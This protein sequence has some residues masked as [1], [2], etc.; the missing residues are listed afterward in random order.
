MA[1]YNTQGFTSLQ[2]IAGAGI[3][4]NVGGVALAA[5]TGMVANLNSYTSLA[6]VADFAPLET[7]GFITVNVAANT[8][9]A[10]TNAVPYAFQ[11]NLGNSFFSNAVSTQMYLDLGNGD[12]GK[13]E[14]VLAQVQSFQIVTNQTI[15]DAL[16][17]A[18]SNVVW[19]SADNSM[20]YGFSSIS[21]AL[22][23]LGYDMA[24]LGT[25]ISLNNLNNLGSPLALLRQL[26]FA[27]N[28]LPALEDELVVAGISKERLG[29]IETST[30]T[31]QEQKLMYTAMTKITG[32]PLK[33]ILS[34]LKVTTPGLTT[35]ADLL[36]PYKLFPTS[37][38]SLT[39]PTKIGVRG[40]YMDNQGTVN[41]EL[42]TILPDSVLYPLQGNPISQNFA[43]TYS[44]LK[45][46]I[47]DDQ[48]LAN[49]A[50]QAGLQE[51]KTIFNSQ[52]PLLAPSVAKLETNY[53]LNF[54]NALTQPV[55]QDVLNFYTGNS[56]AYGS[57]PDGLFLLTDFI[58][59]PTGYV[60]SANI[61]NTADILASMT[62]NGAFNNLI[63]GSNGVITIMTKCANADFTTNISG[64]PYHPLFRTLIPAGNPGAGSYFSDISA[65]LS[66]QSA[67]DSGLIPAFNAN[68]T[69]ITNAYPEE[70]SLCNS[71]WN[72][73]AAQLNMEII[74]LSEVPVVWAN[75]T[76]NIKPMSLVTNLPYYAGD[77]DQGGAA[78]V[79]ESLAN[80]N[81]QSGQ[82]VIAT[83]R[84]SR[85]QGWLNRAGIDTTEIVANTIVFPQAD[86]ST[87]QYTVAQADSEKIV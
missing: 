1:T 11:S 41:S 40:I 22:E 54:I 30:F 20:T 51:I 4:G 5:N 55:P 62:A 74:N 75:L 19:T 83:M 17:Q 7:S 61:G 53:G 32:Q 16:N 10:L 13:F 66:I 77:T 85:N 82:A 87:G 8:F 44:T 37:Y 2:L 28:L 59:T 21:L 36:N 24:R 79:F 43:S 23:A 86:L 76:P 68:V 56:Y 9:P 6:V 81:C 31:L 47:P 18:N 58:G 50:L 78:Y 39:A 42:R 14:Q 72:N 60:Q 25:A 67:F 71:N 29:T 49:K 64:D 27:G 34:I 3:L 38:S 46:I 57:G 15:I 63:N 52:M 65:N 73:A 84:E 69:A 48:A 12:L 80:T 26:A 35:M 33:Q 45:Q 70:V